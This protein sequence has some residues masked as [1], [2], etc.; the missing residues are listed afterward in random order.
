VRDFLTPGEEFVPYGDDD[1]EALVAHYLEHE[2]ERA[3]IARAGHERI[4][5]YSLRNRLVAMRDALQAAGP[6]RPP[7]TA[8]DRALGRGTALLMTW[9]PGNAALRELVTAV[10]LAPDDPR[11]LNAS[12]L[13]MLRRGGSQCL[14]QAIETLQTAHTMAPH[15]LP[16]YWNLAVLAGHPRPPLEALAASAADPGQLDGPIL[17]LG[18]SR[19][20]VEWSQQLR[21]C[22]LDPPPSRARSPAPSPLA[23]A[24]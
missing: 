19:E 23:P 18:Y 7:S 22:I 9:S 1:F 6:G 14:E 15:Y 16:A 11:P 13:A 4:R 20:A 17:P 5:D 12:A 3:R 24:S 10:K 21:R 2:D 8:A